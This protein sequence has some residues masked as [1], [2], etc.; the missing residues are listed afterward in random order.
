MVGL[1]VVVLFAEPPGADSCYVTRLNRSRIDRPEGFGGMLL[2]R[3]KS[4][5]K[6]LMEQ[7]LLLMKA[8]L[9]AK[10]PREPATD[11]Y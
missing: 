11:R 10:R 4:R 8:R 3:I 1:A 9:E 7:D 2:G 6:E 5:M